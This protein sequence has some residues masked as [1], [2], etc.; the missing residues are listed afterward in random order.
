MVTG[1]GVGEGERKRRAA[2]IMV[3]SV[4]VG[5]VGVL[6]AVMAGRRMLVPSQPRCQS[7]WVR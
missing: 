4:M 2:A 7:Q 3:F 5:A 1:V 6:A